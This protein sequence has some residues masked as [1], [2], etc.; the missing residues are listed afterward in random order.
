[1]FSFDKL[2]E[3]MEDKLMKEVIFEINDDDTQKQAK[4]MVEDFVSSEHPNLHK[5]LVICDDSNNTDSVIN[6]GQFALDV[7]VQET[8]N[9]EY[10]KLGFVVVRTG[11]EFN[12]AVTRFT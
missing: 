5:F 6:S 1:M 9:S 11:V 12:D 2:K 3:M 8:E 7:Y 10:R 4:K